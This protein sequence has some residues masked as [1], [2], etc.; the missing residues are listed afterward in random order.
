MQK[1]STHKYASGF[2][3][4]ELLIVIATLSDFFSRARH[5]LYKRPPL[6]YPPGGGWYGGRFCTEMYGK[7]RKTTE[8]LKPVSLF[9][10]NQLHKI[11]LH[12]SWLEISNWGSAKPLSAVR[13]RPVPPFSSVYYRL[14]KDYS[15]LTGSIDEFIICWIC[16]THVGTLASDSSVGNWSVAI[17]LS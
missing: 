8:H 9:K 2:T 11:Q 4:I 3:L 12:S 10:Y 6:L 7:R 15:W 14:I 13:V 16:K 17:H 5:P 1:L